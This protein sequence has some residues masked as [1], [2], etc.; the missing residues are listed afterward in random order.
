MLS[1]IVSP[2]LAAALTAC[3][4]LALPASSALA[5]DAQYLERGVGTT[6]T[7][8]DGRSGFA[9][10]LNVSIDG[11]DATQ[12]YCVD[13]NHQID[14]GDIVSQAPRSYPC[15]VVYILNNYYPHGPVPEG[16]TPAEEA[17]AVQAA[18]WSFTDGA[19]IASPANIATR[20]YDIAGD[21][22]SQECFEDPPVLP[23]PQTLTLT[24]PSQIAYLLSD[25]H[26]VATVLD[27]NGAPVNY[28]QVHVQRDG[29]S[30]PLDF[31]QPMANGQSVVSWVNDLQQGTDTLVATVRFTVPIGLQFSAPGKQS[32]V[33]AGEP[34][35]GQLRSDAAVVKWIVKG[36]GNGVLET[37]EECD[38]SN[39]VDGDDC[40]SN[41]TMTH[42]GNGVVTAGEQCD[43]ANVFDGDG[44][45]A[46]CQVEDN[47]P[48]HEENC[49]DL[50][51]N[52]GDGLIDCEDPDCT[53]CGKLHKDPAHIVFHD[54]VQAG[55]YF[56][57]LAGITPK[58]A[59][60]P[61][62]EKIGI[63]LKN[64]QGVLF[65]D[66][67]SAGDIQGGPKTFSYLHPK[68]PGVTFVH[69]WKHGRP[70]GTYRVRVKTRSNLSTATTPQMIIELVIGDDAFFSQ[71][72]WTQT[73][74]GWKFLGLPK[75]PR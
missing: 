39:T 38:D 59:I 24:P 16:L 49:T 5:A 4:S 21:A 62:H 15:E 56:G 68:V 11:G 18:I 31:E 48:K 1:Q 34:Q 64:K 30:G 10:I 9:G 40:D 19:V 23:V 74:G 55:D 52:D 58:T 27:N 43:D 7:G 36:C 22:S 75:R 32:I 12:A 13:I 33:L 60:D 37:G 3:L 67:L 17:A 29:V 44:C 53:N 26:V 63:L 45:S 69:I 46:T 57:F 54:K 73:K 51:D 71:G 66:I 70:P 47:T 50:I 14:V 61:A 65:R 35:Q 42:C 72:T 8:T 25:A 28:W 2:R 20:A 41:C 6:I